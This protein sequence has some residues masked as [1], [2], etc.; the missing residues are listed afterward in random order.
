MRS[1]ELDGAPSNL[2]CERHAFRMAAGR[3]PAVKDPAPFR[4]FSVIEAIRLELQAIERPAAQRVPAKM[5]PARRHVTLATAARAREHAAGARSRAFADAASSAIGPPA[6]PR[7][8]RRRRL[9]A[10]L[11]PGLREEVVH[12]GVADA[13]PSA[14]LAAREPRVVEL[15]D[16]LDEVVIRRVPM[17]DGTPTP[18]EL[19]LHVARIDQSML[20]CRDRAGP[21]PS[22]HC[23]VAQAELAG[24]NARPDTVVVRFCVG[25]GR[26]ALVDRRR[27]PGGFSHDGLNAT[28]GGGRDR[29]YGLVVRSRP[30]PLS[31]DHTTG[32]LPPGK[33]PA[34]VDDV[35]TAFVDAFPAS[36]NRPVIFTRWQEHRRA[37]SELIASG[38]QWVD[39]SFTTAKD[40]P[41]DIDVLTILDHGDVEALEPHQQITLGGLFTGA[42]MRNICRCDAY[43]AV[44]YP[45]G[46]P[47]R[48]TF[49][50]ARDFWSD[51]Y[52][53]IRENPAG[54]K[55]FAEVNL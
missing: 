29:G 30:L 2:R 48:Q 45:V 18:L 52:Q 17:S 33:H 24:G 10:P 40:E 34:S 3:A 20:V 32:A 1:D 9:V 27:Q 15:H 21:D 25:A 51:L 46:H 8:G 50:Q 13:E 7:L 54:R 43:L 41:K 35:R 22:K 37:V 6:T 12:L 4:A 16:P 36:R 39:G 23:R 42:K 28:S 11:A 19:A 53:R 49:E 47:A 55:G 31:I 44:E 38:T 5:C 14:D 26:Y